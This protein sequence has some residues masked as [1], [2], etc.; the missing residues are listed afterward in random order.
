MPIVMGSN[1][2]QTRTPV[3]PPPAI[4]PA[5][6]LVSLGTN[7]APEDEV[8][9][10]RWMGGF[11]YHPHS[12]WQAEVIDD[13]DGRTSTSLYPGLDGAEFP[14][15]GIEA[16]VPF[17]L[18]HGEE[19]SSFGFQ[20]YGWEQRA[21]AGLEA[22]TASALEYEFWSGEQA[23]AHGYPQRYLAM[24]TVASGGPVVDLTPST[25]PVTPRR[26]LG[27]LE[28]ALA[29]AG[30]AAPSGAQAVT[31]VSTG[32]P[33]GAGRRGMI[34]CL[35][36]FS[37]MWSDLLRRDGRYLLT[38]LDTIV[39]PGSGYPG[40]GPGGA[41]P[42]AGTAWLYATSLVYT[43]LSPPEIQDPDYL[44]HLDRSVNTVKIQ[45]QRY[46]AA[47]WD[48][49]AHYAVQAQIEGPVGV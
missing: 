24:P 13:C 4:A 2:V 37:A 40:T 46:A 9:G 49:V 39:V 38:Y 42:A 43:R 14:R 47:Y 44:T 34:H 41:T 29:N 23:Q 32:Q 33:M 36:E 30:S 17:T 5:L 21:L 45:A 25:G 31:N 1:A 15:P 28:Q 11:A 27:L 26:A 3:P 7:L 20:A 16:Y 12:A 8:I 10:L 18:V 6:S 48:N 19:C 35:P 22:K